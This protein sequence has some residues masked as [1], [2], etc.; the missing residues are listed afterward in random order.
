MLIQTRALD[1]P[2]GSTANGTD[3]QQWDVTGGGGANQKF[4]IIA[5]GDFFALHPVHAPNSAL[6][7][8][9]N[10]NAN[11][12]IVQIWEK[13]PS[14]YMDSQKFK[15]IMTSDGLYAIQSFASYYFKLIAVQGGSK[16]NGAK[17]VHSDSVPLN[18][19]LW[20]LVPSP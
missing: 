19:R 20:Y 5:S 16:N 13:Y 4:K 11:D 15:I 8:T 17:I 10:S 1:V 14:G 18:S 2:N 9:N 6:E 3:L 12:A 7:I